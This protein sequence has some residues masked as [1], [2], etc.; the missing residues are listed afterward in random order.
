MLETVLSYLLPVL[1]SVLAALA[2]Y[3]IRLLARRFKIELDAQAE[4][5][6][7]LAVRRTIFAVEELAA[8]KLKVESK[9]TDKGQAA[10][11]TLQALFPNML[12]EELA[13]ILDEELGQTPGI[14]ASP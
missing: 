2:S 13:R 8:R 3:A 10:L 11:S 9:P 4:A 1:A 5:A 14:G 6:L 7:R 12:P